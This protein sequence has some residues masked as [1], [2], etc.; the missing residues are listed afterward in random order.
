MA[1]ELIVR[2]NSQGVGHFH[3]HRYDDGQRAFRSAL[4]I[5]RGLLRSQSLPPN[6]GDDCGE[7]EHNPMEQIDVGK[8]RRMQISAQLFLPRNHSST[9][10]V[11]VRDLPTSGCHNM[12]TF[13]DNEFVFHD[14]IVLHSSDLGSSN[15]WCLMIIISVL[16]FNLG[17]TEH[18]WVIAKDMQY[19]VQPN[20]DGFQNHCRHRQRL[21]KKA[22]SLYELSYKI[23]RLEGLGTSII[24]RMALA[25]NLGTLYAALGNRSKSQACF[26][27]LLTQLVYYTRHHGI[28]SLSDNIPG[29]E[30]NQLEGFFHNTL[31]QILTD[32]KFAPGA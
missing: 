18:L 8:S 5:A 13:S 4:E 22:L 19:S 17:V 26:Q 27:Y 23:Y 16:V 2:L 20:K 24:H 32:P 14:P 7:N 31:S 1:T 6:E 25:N 21:L 12:Q 11:S 28:T 10:S 9:P 15:R 29:V 3:S 30:R